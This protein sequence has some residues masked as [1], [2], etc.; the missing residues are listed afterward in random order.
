MSHADKIFIENFQEFEHYA[1]AIVSITLSKMDNI[2]PDLAC[3]IMLAVWK[4]MQD[5]M[6]FEETFAE[7]LEAKRNL[8]A[9]RR[10]K[11][12]KELQKI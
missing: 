2:D 4:E 6:S 3:E 11:F 10:E 12:E 5:R 9:K 8:R 1:D 7:G